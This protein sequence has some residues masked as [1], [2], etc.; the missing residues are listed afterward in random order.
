MPTGFDVIKDKKTNLIRKGLTGSV[1]IAS[2]TADAV[3]ETTLFDPATGDLVA[4]PAGYTDLGYTTDKGAALSRKITTNEITSWGTIRPTRTDIT[5]DV[6]TM[7]VEAQET[8]LATIGLYTGQDT[9]SLT[10]GD[11][12]VFSIQPPSNPTTRYYRALAV[13]VDTDEDGEFVIARFFPRAT[14]TDIAD[15]SY[16]NQADPILWSVTLTAFVDPVLG[17]DQD[18]LFGGAAALA[19]ASD[20]SVPRTVTADTTSA[21]TTLT[22]T[23]GKFFPSDVGKTVT[24]TGIPSATTIASY[25]SATEVVMSAAASA[26]GTGVTVTVS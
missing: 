1:F 11:N 8:K 14:V 5:G 3:T 10:A 17:Y 18:Y 12:G 15:Q 16:D 19:L 24:G 4:L 22:A 6:S 21:S 7:V 25:T 23:S 2:Y 13:S 20:M 26:T 9:S